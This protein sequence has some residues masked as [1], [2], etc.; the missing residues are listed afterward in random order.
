MITNNFDAMTFLRKFASFI[1]TYSIAVLRFSIRI[2]NLSM[3]SKMRNAFVIKLTKIKKKVS[4]NDNVKIVHIQRY[5]EEDEYSDEYL[6]NIRE[7]M[8]RIRRDREMAEQEK[9]NH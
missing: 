9:V 4:F 7:Q 3:L 1:T 5:P 6:D 2:L 8:E